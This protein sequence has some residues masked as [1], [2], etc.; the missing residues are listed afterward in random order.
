MIMTTQLLC[1]LP[2]IMNSPADV[3]VV[4]H[5]CIHVPCQGNHTVLYTYY[6]MPICMGGV[7]V[8]KVTS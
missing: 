4:Y 2:P 5:A 7:S 6:A 8:C 3:L 1:S